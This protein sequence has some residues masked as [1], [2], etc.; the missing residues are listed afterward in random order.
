MDLSSIPLFKQLAQQMD[1]LG[2]RQTLIAR[3]IAN[4][5]TP[6]YH[7]VDL[8]ESSFPDLVA[9]AGQLAM[10][11]PVGATSPGTAARMPITPVGTPSSKPEATQGEIKI[12][13]NRVD[14]ESELSRQGEIQGAHDTVINLYRRQVA[15]LKTAIGKSG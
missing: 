14:L 11:Q 2:E 10:V 6:G 9:K 1:R 7:P 15:M 4:A 13:G 5:D 3:N 8:K 12:S